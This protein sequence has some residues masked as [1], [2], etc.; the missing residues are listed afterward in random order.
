MPY[1]WVSV[2]FAALFLNVSSDACCQYGIRTPSETK[3]T[4]YNSQTRLSG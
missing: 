1:Q 4:Y 2:Q 3:M